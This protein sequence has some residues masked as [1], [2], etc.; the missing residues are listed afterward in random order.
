MIVDR[1]LA[2]VQN[3]LFDLNATDWKSTET[4]RQEG[5]G[6]VYDHIQQKITRTIHSHALAWQMRLMTY[7]DYHETRYYVQSRDE[8]LPRINW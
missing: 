4:L 6:Y 3:G 7:D 8:R 1:E 5:G 2:L